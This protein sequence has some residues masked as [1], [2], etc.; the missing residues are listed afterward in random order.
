MEQSPL[1]LQTR[2]DTFE[3]KIVQL[4]RELFHDPDDDDKTEGFWRELFLLR[5]DVLQ[6][7]ALL[8]NTEPDYLLHINHT[9]QQLLGR[10]VDTLEH[11]QTPSDEHALETLA[12]FLDSVLA[13][14]YQSPSADIIEVLAGL[15]N[16]DTVFHQLVDVLDKTISQGGTIELREQAVRV[17]LSI[18]SGAFHTSLLTYFTQRDLFPS[19]TKHIL[20][21]DSARTAIP[22]VVLI[23]ILAN[24]NKFEIYNPYQ[25]R[26]AHL[27][28]EHVTKKLMAAIATACAN[29]REEYVSIQ[30]DSPKPWSIGGTLSYVGLGPLAGKKPPPTVL[31][32]DEAKAKFAELPHKKAAVLL[33]IYE[34]VVHNKQFCSQ[35][36]SDGG[37]GFWELCSFTT[38]LLHHAHR[39]TR[40]ALYSHMALIILRIIVEDSPAN[41]RLCETLGDVRLCRQRPPTLPI[42]K[43]DRPLAT[44]IIDVA[45]DAINHNLRTN[46]DVNLYY[47]AIG[48]LLRIT[49]HLSKSRTRLAYHW[50]ELWRCLLSFVRFCAQYHDA[51][52]NID[53]SN[54]IVHH[55]INLITL[56]LTQGE[57]FMPSSEAVDDLFYK[58]V[59]S[60]KDLEALKTRYGLENSAAGP[61]IQTLIDASLHFKEAFDKSNK[62]DKGVSTKDVMKVIKDGYETLSIEAREGTDHWTP[63]REQDY[64]AEIKKITRVVVTD[65]RKFSLPTN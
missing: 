29:L 42:T 21:A 5:P 62:K 15:D 32:E 12:V 23:G 35:L 60:H 20:E 39:S 16:V 18:T 9:S 44:V 48:I 45:T 10:C 46:L 17:V 34:F 40:A 58:V 19:L 36:I 57:A 11:A 13:K 6:F 53:G 2:P 1:T 37:R 28:D 59:E 41:K 47:S 61:N 33:S 63:F 65:A 3:P 4:Y 7:K 43:G 22:S 52:R 14:R 55:T 31:S 8:D 50:N 26:I 30:D 64:K 56:C 27:D 51:L 54:V 49:T 24:C 38:Y 25:S